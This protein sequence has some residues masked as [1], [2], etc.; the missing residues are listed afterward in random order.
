[1][2]SP[3]SRADNE[4]AISAGSLAGSGGVDAVIYLWHIFIHA[5]IQQIYTDHLLELVLVG[6]WII[7]KSDSSFPRDAPNL[8]RVTDCVSL[9]ELP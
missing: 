3:N 7:D 1:M 4:L 5:F 9:L 6:W 8:V 2:K